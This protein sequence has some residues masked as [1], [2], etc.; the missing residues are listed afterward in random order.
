MRGFEVDPR[1]NNSQ[2]KSYD[3]ILSQE[4]QII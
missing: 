2:L 3:E 1:E 4:D